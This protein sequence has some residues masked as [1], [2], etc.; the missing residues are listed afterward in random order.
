M[1]RTALLCVLLAG[2]TAFGQTTPP[3]NATVFTNL[4]DKPSDDNPDGWGSCSSCAGGDAVAG[5]YWSAPYQTVP[6]LD[7]DSTQFYL[8]G[9]A[10]SDVLWWNKVG[11]HDNFSH[12]QTDFWMMFGSD[13]A[14]NAQALEFDTFQ[15][16]KGREYMFG[17]QC[18]YAVN[19]WEVWNQKNGKWMK[20]S[21]ACGRFTPNVWSRF[22]WEFHRGTNKRDQNMHYDLL[23]ITQY[24]PDGVTVTSNHTYT[25]NL[26]YPSGPMPTGWSDDLGVQFQMDLA[27]VGGTMSEWADKVTLTAW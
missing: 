21:I 18:D 10:W 20:T 12:F 4:D 17:T 22:V 14:G 7:G 25:V 8:S 15:F 24:A 16:V 1:K 13:A 9:A 3:S 2:L 27:G 19:A 26:A 6:S 11:A 23:T 5:V